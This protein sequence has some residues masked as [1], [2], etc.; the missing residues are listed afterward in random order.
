MF[1]FQLAIF[2]KTTMDFCEPVGAYSITPLSGLFGHG[3]LDS[4]LPKTLSTVVEESVDWGR[5]NHLGP[6]DSLSLRGQGGCTGRKEKDG[7]LSKHGVTVGAL[8]PYIKIFFSGQ[9]T[10]YLLVYL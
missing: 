2:L 4:W 1:N 5:V 7:G 3:I 9:I 6:K 8:V 10:N